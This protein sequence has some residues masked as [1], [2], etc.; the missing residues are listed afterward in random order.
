MAP[1][2]H[3]CR[4]MGSFVATGD[5]QAIDYCK[6]CALAEMQDTLV[7]AAT[8][9]AES[10]KTSMTLMDLIMQENSGLLA[11]VLKQYR[12]SNLPENEQERAKRLIVDLLHEARYWLRT[13]PVVCMPCLESMRST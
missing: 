6:E 8:A 9:I 13:A 4:R 5:P 1:I 12:F 3:D 7:R 10:D 11:A 2:C